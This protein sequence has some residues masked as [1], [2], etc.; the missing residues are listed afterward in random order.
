MAVQLSHIDHF[1]LTVA[2]L[3]RTCAFYEKTLGMRR[4]EFKP[5]R[6]AL[7]FGSCKI[8]PHPAERTVA[9]QLPKSPTPGSADICLIAETPIDD[10]AS[11]LK[12]CGVEIREGPSMRS[13]ATGPIMSVYFHDPD[14]NPI[15]VSSQL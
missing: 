5:G 9:D 10:I 3:E 4:D 6:V 1:V 8:N 7:Y 12:D 14:N 15:E 2:D 11:H 13:G